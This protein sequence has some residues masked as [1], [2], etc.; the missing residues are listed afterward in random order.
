[1]VCVC[2]Y[3][4]LTKPSAHKVCAF[5]PSTSK[6][7]NKECQ[8]VYLTVT[9]RDALEPVR[10]GQAIAWHLKKLF[11][12]QFEIAGVGKMVRNEATF[13]A[14]KKVDDPAKVPASWEKPLAEFRKV[15]E[16]YLMYD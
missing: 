6:F 12:D 13:E 15:R 5:K 3:Y 16:K 11:G 10:A 2:P 4:Y 8:G 1:M 7:A 9:D 14:L